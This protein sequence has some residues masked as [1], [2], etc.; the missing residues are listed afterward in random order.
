MAITISKRNK[1]YIWLISLIF[2]LVFLS[3]VLSPILIEKGKN[4]WDKTLVD[5]IDNVANSISQAFETRTDFLITIS[6]RLKKD[7]HSLQFKSLI[8]QR[9]LFTLLTDKKYQNLSVQIYD[10]KRNLIAWNYEPVLDEQGLN[11]TSSYINQSFFSSQ[12]LFTHLCFADTLNSDKEVML[13]VVSQPVEKHYSLSHK[14]DLT[15]NVADSLSNALSTKV[16]INY[17]PLAQFSKDGRKYS[18]AIQNNFSNKIAVATFDKPSL[19][20]EVNEIQKT[21]TIIQYLLLIAV[22][23][24]LS[25]WFRVYVIKIN[26]KSYRFLSITSILILLRSLLFVFEIPSSFIRSSVNDPSNFSSIFA[27]GIVRSPLELLITMMFLLIIILIGYNF[28]LEHYDENKEVLKQSKIKFAFAI[29]ISTLLFL[30]SFR[31]FGAAIRSVIF[32]STIRYFK[33]FA[34]IPSPPILLMNFNILALGFCSIVFSIIL[35]LY[36]FSL[37]TYRE[38]KKR[39]AL[40][41]ILFVLIQ[42]AAWIFDLLQ[43]EPQGTPIIRIIYITIVFSL[44][45]FVIFLN[46]RTWLIFAYYAF[47]ASIVSVSL[48][49]YYNSQIER[50]SL[51]TTA[52]ELTRTNED[53]IEFMVFQTLVQTQQD[54]RAISSF[55]EWNNFSSDAFIIW[56][57]SLLYRE[58]I[59]SALNFFDAS[60]NFIGGYQTGKIVSFTAIERHLLEMNDSLKIFKETNLYGNGIT[61]NGIVPLKDNDKLLGFAVVSAVYDENHFNFAELPK[62]LLSQRAGI[63]SAVDFTKLKIFDFHNGELMRSY[64]G[65][66]LSPEEQKQILNSEFI[67]YSESWL[68]MNI[69]NESNLIYALKIDSPAKKKILAIALEEKN[70]SWNLSD[71]FKVF[72]VHTIIITFLIIVFALAR[73]RKTKLVFISYR[74]RLIGAF[75]VISIIP[76]IVIALYFR[77]ITEEKNNQLI[78]K[79]LTEMSEQVESYLNL[80]ASSTSVDQLLIFEKAARDL[81]INFSIYADKDLLFS[82]QEVYS[83]VGLLQSTINSSAYTNCVLGKNQRIFSNEKLENI[84]INSVYSLTNFN[85]HNIILKVDDLFNK[86]SIPL[87]DIELD[88]FLFGVFSLAVLLL[89]ILST[90][91]ADQISSP[92]RRL[93]LATKSVGSGDLNVEVNYK[94]NGEIKDLVDGFNMMVKKIEQSQIEIARMERESAWKEM[95]KQVAHEIKN[96]LTPMKLN[97]QQLITAYKDK[98]PKFDL[99]FEKVTAIIISQIETLKNIASEFSNFARMPRLNIEK[100]N[101]VTV[102]REAL[103]LFEEEKYEIKFECAEV[104]IFVNADQDQLKR[105]IINLLR[106]SIQASAK[107]II[108]ALNAENGM[109]KIFVH[110]DGIGIESNIIPN[111]FDENFTTKNSGMGIGLSL[112]KRF[113]ESI[114][115]NISVEKTSKDWTT[116]LITLPLAE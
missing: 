3:A 81:N 102:I 74:T 21:I 25:F 55:Y 75:L 50:E 72:F 95:A 115:G 2:F 73:F 11:K 56:T 32:D 28:V 24:V 15:Q 8:D 86:V 52:H 33:D 31:G 108:V 1:K 76:L 37:S 104:E 111:V 17:S 58:G 23:G 85:N 101:A 83:E 66:N 79:R 44:A 67:S 116:F 60:H 99:I 22:V 6:S 29:V 54:E 45:Y 93:T 92:I 39:L 36:I 42:A 38:Q 71:F 40:F 110:D 87:S 62:I 106:N 10:S 46:R 80:Y 65:V 103:N 12:K 109:C 53:L 114:D 57:G 13:I 61:F 16:E 82:S 91:L 68:N 84:P 63:S 34:L 43:S 97:V 77:N 41:V 96:P 30:L 78:E 105:T 47:A 35:L 18:F 94:T 5:K 112:A 64:G 9:S 107:H 100:L 69:N 70:I 51:K 88:I 90:I 113:V 89:F 98:S 27:F 19:E 26:R 14:D 7:L 48:L 59:P 20:L 49:T 4:N